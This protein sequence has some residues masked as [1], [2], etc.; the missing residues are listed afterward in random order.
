MNENELNE[1]LAPLRAAQPDEATRRAN[2][3]AA[4]HALRP[5]PWWRRSVAVPV[6]IA[7]VTAAALLV[8]VGWGFS[9]RF[10]PADRRPDTT[11]N[12]VSPIGGGL[13]ETLVATVD[14]RR[15][16]EVYQSA[17]YVAGIGFVDRVTRY[18][19]QE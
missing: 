12:V 18:P 17:S 19:A 8:A 3:H 16:G 4:R 13:E 1:L 6:P 5:T 15:E 9:T 7:L 10:D 2:R 11:P 14:R